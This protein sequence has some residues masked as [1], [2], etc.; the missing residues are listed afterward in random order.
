MFLRIL[1][2][3]LRT[4]GVLLCA[5]SLM[6][7]HFHMIIVTPFGNRADFIGAV[8][9]RF[10]SYS[11]WRHGNVGHLFQGRYLPVLIAD[12]IQ[13]LT[14]LCYVFLNPL[15]AGIATKLEG[16][17]WSTYRAT[18]GFEQTPSYLSL[19]WLQTLFPDC[20]LKEAQRRF[21]DLMQNGKPVVAYLRQQDWSVD[22]DAVKRVIR[23]YTGEKLRIG[24]MPRR[25]RSVLRP[26]LDELFR[27]RLSGTL[28][29]HAI[30]EARVTDGYRVVEIARQ[31]KMSR[32]T[33]SKIFRGYASKRISD[34][35]GQPPDE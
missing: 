31:L 11:N 28:L 7:N 35:W 29:A 24:A 30:Y 32:A 19:E 34:S 16:Y 9:S 17:R 20:D 33:V 27:Y 10:A 13:L 12:D 8:E 6:G 26:P 18:A 23:S 22:P 1:F 4:H 21:H 25:Y 5:L 2:E 14:A 3:E 15:R